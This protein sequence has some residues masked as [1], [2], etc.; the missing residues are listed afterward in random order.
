M[1]GHWSEDLKGDEDEKQND[2]GA[3]FDEGEYIFRALLVKKGVGHEYDSKGLEGDE[4]FQG[5]SRVSEEGDDCNSEEEAVSEEVEDEDLELERGGKLSPVEGA[6]GLHCAELAKDTDALEEGEG[7]HE[8]DSDNVEDGIEH[9]GSGGKGNPERRDK[10][11]DCEFDVE[12][13]E[14]AGN[15]S[16]ALDAATL[17]LGL[18]AKMRVGV[19]MAD[20][21]YHCEDEAN[22][23]NSTEVDREENE[24][25]DVVEEKAL[26]LK[27]SLKEAAREG[28]LLLEG[29]E[30]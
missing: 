10:R 14:E 21:A 11:G 15:E 27:F 26:A 30:V 24:L 28:W 17:L 19:P 12:L 13:K 22:G 9:F 8:G 29:L 1:R 7:Y 23:D 25:G 20:V 6:A 5:N 16:G 18:G 4:D 3:P 2:E